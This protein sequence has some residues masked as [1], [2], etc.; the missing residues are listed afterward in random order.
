MRHSKLAA[1]L[2]TL[3]LATTPQIAQAQS[4]DQLF[5]QGNAAQNA[6]RYAEAETDLATGDPF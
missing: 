2:I 5:Q 4:V 3:A 6:G 1:L